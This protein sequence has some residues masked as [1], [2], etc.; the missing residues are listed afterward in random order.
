MIQG[1]LVG[2]TMADLIREGWTLR[3]VRWDGYHERYAD[4][5]I[6]QFFRALGFTIA[7]ETLH[8]SDPE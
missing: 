4:V 7:T 8:K 1:T 6:D 3:L 5:P 2:K